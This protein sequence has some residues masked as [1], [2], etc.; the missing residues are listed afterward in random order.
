MK[1]KRKREQTS[2]SSNYG[3]GGGGLV[4]H[5][6]LLSRSYREAEGKKEKKGEKERFDLSGPELQYQKQSG[7]SMRTQRIT[8]ARILGWLNKKRLRIATITRTYTYK[9][10][11][12]Q[13]SPPVFYVFAFKNIYI[14]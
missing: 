14:F 3:G 5:H 11:K 12:H 2:Q 4:G 1:K 7:F 9:K 8:G 13:H 6:C 10:Q